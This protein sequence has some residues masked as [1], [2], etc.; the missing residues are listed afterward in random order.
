MEMYIAYKFKFFK[1]ELK[2]FLVT[3]SYI[4]RTSQFDEKFLRAGYLYKR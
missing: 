2:A 4:Q 3:R 1:I